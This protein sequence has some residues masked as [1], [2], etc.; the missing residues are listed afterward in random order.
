MEFPAVQF[1]FPAT[2]AYG[3]AVREFAQFHPEYHE[4]LCQI[5]LAWPNLEA[6]L[7]RSV[8]FVSPRFPIAD[9]SSPSLLVRA[10]RNGVLSGMRHIGER[11]FQP[12]L[13]AFLNTLSEALATTAVYGTTLGQDQEK[14][15]LCSAPLCQWAGNFDSIVVR[16]IRAGETE[17][18]ATLFLVYGR[19]LTVSDFALLLD[20]RGEPAPQLPLQLSASLSESLSIPGSS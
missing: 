19:V 7:K 14:W 1:V 20:R 8:F 9:A 5:M 4:D 12:F 2:D 11:A 6:I 10:I 15:E 13:E 16:P 18:R 17:R 3:S